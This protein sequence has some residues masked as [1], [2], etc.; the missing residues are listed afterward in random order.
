[1]RAGGRDVRVTEEPE[2]TPRL[3]AESGMTTSPV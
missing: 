2:W 1:V 3:R